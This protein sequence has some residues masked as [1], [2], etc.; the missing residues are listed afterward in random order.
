MA[1]IAQARPLPPPL[2]PDKRY[3]LS[4]MRM[5]DDKLRAAVKRAID[6]EGLVKLAKRLQIVPGTLQR[7][8]L[9]GNSHRGTV[10]QIEKGLGRR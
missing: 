3:A 6:R 7:F 1:G 4:V 10:A 8:A 9:G 2:A 5:T